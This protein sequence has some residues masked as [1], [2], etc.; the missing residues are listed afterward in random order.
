MFKIIHNISRRGVITSLLFFILFSACSFVAEKKDNKNLLTKSFYEICFYPKKLPKTP[1]EEIIPDNI[2][3][4]LRSL[5]NE[6]QDDVIA[7]IKKSCEKI[8][9]DLNR[10]NIKDE[11]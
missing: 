9:F 4:E 2:L 3:Q 5:K 11:A 6:Q 10:Q 8:L 1:L 7:A